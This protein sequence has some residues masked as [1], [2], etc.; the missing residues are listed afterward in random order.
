MKLSKLGMTRALRVIS[1]GVTR[2]NPANA[3][4]WNG[5]T[6]GEKPTSSAPSGKK[7][8]T[9]VAANTTPGTVPAHLM[10]ME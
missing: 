8:T 10:G 6:V 1:S 5:E 7:R 4:I 9:T 3:D 2:F